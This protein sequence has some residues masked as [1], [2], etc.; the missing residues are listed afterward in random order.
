M[1]NLTQSPKILKILVDPGTSLV[2]VLYNVNDG[3][4]RLLT[5]G[6]EYVSLPNQKSEFLPSGDTKRAEVNAWVQVGE[7]DNCHLLGQLANSYRA[8]TNLKKTKVELLHYKILGVLGAIAKN[9]NLT[10]EYRV[11]LALLIPFN[12]I[13]YLK[14]DKNWSKDLIKKVGGFR[15]QTSNISFELGRIDIKPEGFGYLSYFLKNKG[16][17]L[18]NSNT[19]LIMLGY[20]N[21][22]CLFFRG[23]SLD[24]S[25]TGTSMFGYNA[26]LN[27][28]VG[29][30]PYLNESNILKA[31]DTN[32]EDSSSYLPEVG[33]KISDGETKINFAGLAQV[34]DPE[35]K[36]VEVK[37]LREVYSESLAEYWTL[38]TDWLEQKLPFAAE[39]DNILFCGGSYSFL[40]DRLEVFAKDYNAKILEDKLIEELP[41]YLLWRRSPYL[42][43]FKK[44]NFKHR[45]ADAWGFFSS[46][47][48]YDKSRVL[49]IETG[50]TREKE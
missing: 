20:R 43:A 36:E 49:N 45:F 34:H 9:E 8:S 42:T 6:P 11:E 10:T 33:I 29:Q 38:L 44:G 46:F 4:V 31:I 16:S 27:N 1:S 26:M 12:E 47:S 22:S 3:V 24:R 7:D 41:K 2:K 39:V 25:C 30:V 23:G 37:M 15:F 18:K 28:M 50:K 13:D 48:N 17:T 40:A 21:T 5:M 19:A 35:K 32:V 14:R